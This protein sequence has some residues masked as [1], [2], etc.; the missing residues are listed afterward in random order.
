[1]EERQFYIDRLRVA[2]TGLVIF[3]HTAITYGAS[4][5][6]FYRDV[7]P[8]SE[9]TGQVLTLFCAVN[10]SF[11]MGAFFLLAGL[12]VPL[13]LQRKGLARFLGERVVRLGIP[14][15]VFSVTLGPL[16]VL[17]ARL[18]DSPQSM[19]VTH[20][21]PSWVLGP[22][23]FPWALLLFSL[24]YGLFR[25]VFPGAPHPAN[26]NMP[27]HLAWISAAVCVGGVALLIRQ[28]MPVGDSVLGLQAGYFASYLFL[29]VL[30]CAALPR[31]WMERLSWSHVRWWLLTSMVLIPALPVALMW[32]QRLDPGAQDFS[33]GLNFS[34]VAYAFW[35]PFV[36][37]GIIAALLVFF[38]DFLN[39]PSR[40]WERWGR[41]AYGAFFVHAPL[42]V[43][44]SVALGSW[45]APAV[46]K[47]LT[48][49]SLA[50]VASF[51][52]SGLLL[53]SKLV[54]KVL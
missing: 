7:T 17:L 26:Q 32:A 8:D 34:S 25:A 16:T 12:Y 45:D 47:F 49:G 54:C 36:A 20:N 3:H 10:Q 29:F 52:T 21:L 9:A 43:A 15:L 51:V 31:A 1:M 46:S 22:L 2:L 24:V 39:A 13:A 18:G 19:A 33:G 37:W 38:R 53:R 42:T 4:G 23:W 48:V 41:Q 35:E 6:W 5:S 27:S 14:V 11:F 28:W 40:H 50:V 30:G 44:L